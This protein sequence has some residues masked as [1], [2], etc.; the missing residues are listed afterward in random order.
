[1]ARLRWDRVHIHKSGARSLEELGCPAWHFFSTGEV[2]RP[3]S[4]ETPDKIKSVLLGVPLYLQF[5]DWL[6]VPDAHYF[7][8]GKKGGPVLVVSPQR[9][10]VSFGLSLTDRMRLSTRWESN[11]ENIKYF[12][13]VPLSREKE[14]RGSMSYRFLWWWEVSSGAA[15]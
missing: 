8:T 6:I 11:N 12:S 4:D 9:E 14:T 10:V 3:E 13:S 2:R 7:L 1:M 5:L 15:Y